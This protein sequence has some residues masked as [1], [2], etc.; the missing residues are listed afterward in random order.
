MK[1]VNKIPRTQ[2][3]EQP[4]RPDFELS[5]IGCTECGYSTN[6]CGWCTASGKVASGTITLTKPN[7]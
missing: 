5:V 4:P 7:N 2:E 1:E 3:Q 6:R